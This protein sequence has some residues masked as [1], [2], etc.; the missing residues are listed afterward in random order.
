MI[1]RWSTISYATTEPYA[2]LTKQPCVKAIMFHEH[3]AAR[4]YGLSP[5]RHDDSKFTQPSYPAWGIYAN[6]GLHQEL[7]HNYTRTICPGVYIDNKSWNYA[8]IHKI[9]IFWEVRVSLFPRAPPV[10]KTWSRATSKHPII[11]QTRTTARPEADWVAWCGVTC[12]ADYPCLD[13][14]IPKIRKSTQ[15]INNVDETRRETPTPP[16]TRLT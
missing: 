4:P 5:T 2:T 1:Q 6:K 15:S 3:R 13:V 16:T 12:R 10:M 7:L 11:L 14:P 9:H 8:E